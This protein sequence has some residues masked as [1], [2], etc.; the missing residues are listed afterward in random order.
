VLQNSQRILAAIMKN[1]LKKCRKSVVISRAV[2]E[3]AK[4][5]VRKA[6]E[7]IVQQRYW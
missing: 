6:K 3:K 4:E 5:K 1:C 7:K 2:F